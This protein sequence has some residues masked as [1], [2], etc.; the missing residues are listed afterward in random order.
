[1]LENAVKYTDSDDAIELRATAS[2]GILA[3]EV[4]DKGCGIPRESLE[5]IFERFARADASRT[6][7][8]G[9]VGLG[10]AIVDAIARSHGGRC[11][12]HSTDAETI[13]TLHLPSFRPIAA[14]AQPVFV[15]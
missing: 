10:L 6:R 2:Y 15:S 5:R 11:T 13:F 12:V 9:G 1:L 7:D 8:R 3:I 14:A 4:A